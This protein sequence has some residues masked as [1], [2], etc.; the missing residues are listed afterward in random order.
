MLGAGVGY[1]GSAASVD[2]PSG[3]RDHGADQAL[4]SAKNHAGELGARFSRFNGSAWISLS[5]QL[6]PNRVHSPPIALATECPVEVSVQ[7]GASPWRDHWESEDEVIQSGEQLDKGGK[8]PMVPSRAWVDEV[9]T[10]KQGDIDVGRGSKQRGLL[11]S[12]WTNRYKV[13]KFGRDQAGMEDS[14]QKQDVQNK[15]VERRLLG[16]NFLQSM[17]E[18]STEEEEMKQQQRMGI[19]KDL[20]RKIRSKGRM[21]AKNRR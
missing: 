18:E 1:V 16:K 11:P 5:S 15:N 7:S 8:V 17:Q 4:R 10:L 3:V 20:I 14:A 19:M 2:G 12:F 6:T 13:S 21:D 9:K